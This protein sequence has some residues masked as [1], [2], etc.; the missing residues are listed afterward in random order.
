M[1]SCAAIVVPYG[2]IMDTAT[3]VMST[4]SPKVETFLVAMGL[5]LYNIIHA[6]S[7]VLF[8]V[9]LAEPM[10]RKINRIKN[11]FGMFRECR[12]IK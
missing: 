10:L 7:A 3:V 8:L 11:K 1:H 9:F 5:D 12:S 2:L 6:A 4:D